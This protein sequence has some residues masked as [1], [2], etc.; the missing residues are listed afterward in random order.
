MPGAVREGDYL[1]PSRVHIC[2]HLSA[3]QYVRIFNHWLAG[4]GLDPHKYGTHSL[5]R[6]RTA[7]V[8]KKTANLRA[9]QP[10]FG[11]TKLAAEYLTLSRDRS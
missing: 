7:L 5:R 9:V 4:T 3:R 2:L 11:H 6:T 10:L 8:Y 1:F